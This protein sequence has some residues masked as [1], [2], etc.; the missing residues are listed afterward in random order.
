[1]KKVIVTGFAGYIAG[2]LIPKLIEKGYYVRGYDRRIPEDYHYDGDFF[3]SITDISKGIY[4]DDDVV[5][6]V[7]L[8][9][10]SGIANCEEDVT[11]TMRSNIEATLNI[12]NYAREI[13]VPVVFASSQAAENGGNL[14]AD[15]KKICE[16]IAE[17]C[18]RYPGGDVR[19]LRFANVYGG[20]GYL[21]KKNTAFANFIRCRLE[22]KVAEVHG[23]G[24]QYRDFVHVDDVCNAIILALENECILFQPI[25]IGTGIKTSI[26]HLARDVVQCGYTLREDISSG[27]DGN[28]ADTTKAKELLGFEAQRK[29][30]NIME[31]YE[32]V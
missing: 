20:K 7:H 19:I 11:D 31:E 17:I 13:G 4:Q 21:E 23:Y 16:E 2:N 12:F 6:I 18:N 3:G 25:D 22:G 24:N 28:V 29:I 27:V 14:Y 15:T 26:L 9:A 30:E 1:M 32:H 5:G 10:I 8:A